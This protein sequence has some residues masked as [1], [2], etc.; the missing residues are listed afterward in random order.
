[1]PLRAESGLPELIRPMLAAPGQLPTGAGWAFEFK[2]DGVRAVTYVRGG[3]VRAMTRNDLEVSATYP[4]LR[5]LATLPGDH[6]VVLDGEIVALGARRQPDFGRLQARMHVARPGDELL[7]RVPVVYYVF[8]LLH[9]DGRSLLGA[10]YARRREELGGLG[11]GGVPGVRVPPSFTEVDGED[12]LAVA[13]D[14]GLEGVV[15]KR[16]TSRYE[17]GRRSTAWVKV[18]LVRTQEVLIGGWRPGDGRRA[19]T[20]GSLLLGVPSDDGLRYVGKV[21]T[22]FTHSALLD[23]QERLRPLAR[24]GSPFVDPVPADQA[25]RAHW[26]RPELVGEVEY[27]TWTTDG[28]LRH[29]SW[30]GLRPDKQPGEVRLP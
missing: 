11:L 21:G 19:G 29:S 9:V 12:V 30:R 26:V 3:R 15:A 5:A 28:R 1:M 13:S 20:I 27:R 7:A 14:Y 8:D 6:E 16:V 4:E 25:R 17:P 18:P 10:P 2:W 22:G 24:T 23:L